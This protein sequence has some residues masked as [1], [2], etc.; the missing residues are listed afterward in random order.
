MQGLNKGFCN[1]E[2]GYLMDLVSSLFV[3]IFLPYIWLV[4][5][6]MGDN[7]YK[8]LKVLGIKQYVYLWKVYGILDLV[9]EFQVSEIYVYVL[10]YLKYGYD[11]RKLWNLPL[12]KVFL[13]NCLDNSRFLSKPNRMV[14]WLQAA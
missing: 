1:Q 14:T 7:I 11:Q 9:N 4:G 3:L 2:Y 12:Q 5:N 8:H 10:I 6:L 13:K